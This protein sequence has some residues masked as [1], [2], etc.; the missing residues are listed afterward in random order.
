[1][2]KKALML[3]LLC[4]FRVDLCVAQTDTL[5]LQYEE[6]KTILLKDNLKIL[7]AYYDISIAEADVVQAKLWRNPTFVWNQDLY[8]I[9]RNEYFNYQNQF[10]IQIEQVFSVS[11]KHTWGVRMA[12][13]DRE[14]NKLQLQDVLRGLVFELGQKYIQLD[15]LEQKQRL[16][17]ETVKK[18]DILIENCEIKLKAGA[19]SS[20]EV[21]R[22]KSE[23]IG[24]KSEALNNQN[25]VLEIMSDLRQL[26]NLK[27]TVY[28]KI[29]DKPLLLKDE[30]LLVQTLIQD[31]TLQRSDV[32]LAQFE[33]KYQEGNLKRQR[34]EAIPD[35]KLGYQPSDKGSNY[36]RPYQGLVLEFGLP[37]FDRNQ[38]GIKKAKAQINKAQASQLEVENKVRN[39]VLTAFSQWIN[40]K[41]G[42]QNLT[43]EFFGQMEEL[44]KNAD[45][46]YD[47]KN[48]NLLQYI[49]LRRIY[50]DNQLQYINLQQQ[51][52]QTVNKLNFTVGKEVL[53]F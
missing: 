30:S 23:R 48:I 34:A 1:M 17:A 35:I 41:T 40:I 24:V 25:D 38:G 22:L 36:V 45:Q 15:A 26:L 39:E 10:L 7:S 52:R 32:Q 44:N 43:P 18:Y 20:N 16:Y 46:N 11:G 49:D 12:K 31:A 47:K 33:I 9:A 4:G 8:S 6:A 3:F 27:E 51:Y 19:I 29:S 37:F 42:F 50:V 53:G 2:L 28:V 21:L 14:R 5:T 13:L